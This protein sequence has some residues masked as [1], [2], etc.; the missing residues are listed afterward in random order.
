MKAL[1]VVDGPLGQDLATTLEGAVPP[2]R[3]QRLQPGELAYAPPTD[4]IV[5]DEAMAESQREKLNSNH[6][7]PMLVVGRD[8]EKP[9][10][11]AALRKA[12]LKAAKRLPRT[13]GGLVAVDP[14][15]RTALRVLEQVA[16]RKQ[17]VLVTGP[18]GVGKE[19]LAT[20]LH[21]RSGRAGAFVPVNCAA[22]NESLAESTLFGHVRGAFTGAVS[23]VP[24]AFVE[25]HR[26]TLFLDEI[27][28]LELAVQAKLLRALEECSV[29]AV[30]ASKA[31]E[32][33]VRIVAATNRDLRREVAA[34]RFRADLYFRLATFVVEVPALRE[35]P[36]DLEALVDCFHR[37]HDRAAQVRLSA[38]ARGWL[39]RYPWPGNVR[40]L[41]NVMER[42]LALAAPGELTETGLL[43]LAP[44]LCTAIANDDGTREKRTTRQ[45]LAIQEQE[46]I[47]ARVA[48]GGVKRQKLADELGIHRTT[49]WRKMKRLVP[50]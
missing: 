33:D 30:G 42:V 4:L 2:F 11:E 25:A 12:A 47:H 14:P 18:T 29:R 21:A 48:R 6:G 28:E 20:H 23:N 35:R 46:M 32:V 34:G 15:L 41:R 24:G 44:E 10:T 50:S 8:I 22:F 27:G 13:A 37:Q 38:G 16:R 1:V 43:E 45:A 26:G 3:V 31:T 39:A 7:V 17:G 40:E 5:V 49:L 19:L 9:F 36:G